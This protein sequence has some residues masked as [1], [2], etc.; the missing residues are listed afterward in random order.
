MQSEDWSTVGP[1][2]PARW[3][4][5][6]QRFSQA[7]PRDSAPSPCEEE[8]DDA[9][10]DKND[11]VFWHEVSQ[12]S[13]GSGQGSG[14]PG[15]S[16][17]AITPNSSYSSNGAA[18][19]EE[20]SALHLSKLT[21]QHPPEASTRDRTLHDTL[22]TDSSLP[23]PVRHRDS[24][25]SGSSLIANRSSEPF[26]K[27]VRTMSVPYDH[28]KTQ[29]Y[30]D[31]RKRS[32][33]ISAASLPFSRD[34]DL[35][36]DSALTQIR[37]QT[38]SKKDPTQARRH[39]RNRS[40]L[41]LGLRKLIGRRD[42][43]EESS[44][45]MI[46][47]APMQSHLS[48]L[49]ASAPENS[50]SR[51]SRMLSSRASH[52]QHA[53]LHGQTVGHMSDYGHKDVPQSSAMLKSSSADRAE[54]LDTFSTAESPLRGA[55]NPRA[56]S[57]NKS[58]DGLSRP[59]FPFPSRLGTGTN[60]PL[61]MQ[62]SPRRNVIEHVSFD[63]ARKS[64]H[65]SSPAKRDQSGT[66]YTKEE[67]RPITFQPVAK[68]GVEVE[69]SVHSHTPEPM[70]FGLQTQFHRPFSMN[71]THWQDPLNPSGDHSHCAGEEQQTLASQK[72]NGGGSR[73]QVSFTEES[74]PMK[75]RE[76]LLVSEPNLSNLIGSAKFGSSFSSSSALSA[77]TSNASN[78]GPPLFARQQ[79]SPS[80]ITTN[81]SRPSGRQCSVA[82]AP[83]NHRKRPSFGLAIAPNAHMAFD[84]IPSPTIRSRRDDA[85]LEAQDGAKTRSLDLSPRSLLSHRSGLPPA[86]LS[87]DNISSK[88][89]QCSTPERQRSTA[90][91]LDEGDSP[92]Q[93]QRHWALQERQYTIFSPAED[94]QAVKL[95][96]ATKDI[97]FGSAAGMVSKVFEHPFD[98]VKVRLQTQS[99][100]R[101]PQ[102]A[103]AFDCFKQTYL[104]EGVRG[105][106]RGLSMP[107]IGATLENACLF[108]TY[109]QIQRGLRWWKGQASS[110]SAL[111][112]DAE[113][114]LS[115]AQ[116][117][118]AG[119]G[120]GSVTSFVLTPIELIKCKMQV[121]MITR[122][123]QP[124]GNTASATSFASV[125][126]QQ[127]RSMSAL[128]DA[129]KLDGPLALVRRT[130]AADGL[131]GLWLGQTGTLLRETGG[132]TAWFLAFESC[133][134]Y[135][136]AKKKAASGRSDVTKKELTSL[137]LIG[138]G[139][140]SG[141]SYNVVLFPADSVKSTMQTEQEM[142]RSAT[143]AGTKFKGTG[144]FATFKKIYASR[145][146]RGLYAG[147]GVTCLR[148]APS[149][150]IIFLMYN[151][152]EAFADHHGL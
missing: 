131:R 127:V 107:V 18:I 15:P 65:S 43:G 147:C 55:R 4:T 81:F 29:T 44:E 70:R 150:A 73:A 98:L 119:A 46:I 24:Q 77:S 115:I 48:D 99:G 64:T 59:F 71:Y 5:L 136:I 9:M 1:S 94:G 50:L 121:Q 8:I 78:L 74:A 35:L 60:A 79:S 61:S 108:F 34:R 85:L 89:W 13:A 141:I 26:N 45:E 41:L 152:L 84:S 58:T 101:P 56:H 120:A 30:T 36:S 39:A 95:S 122:A 3:S 33:T 148:S 25:G 113:A 117:A 133:S 12:S 132:S 128:A 54:A 142:M 14:Q 114:P 96:Q 135:L 72:A 111:Q 51:R 32:S 40:S 109:N 92:P 47:S 49:T 31:A 116:L 102:Y 129:R 20:I 139:A 67:A 57:R 104:N 90:V 118:I 91:P 21:L 93:L 149:S 69:V 2:R 143:S 80:Q 28:H 37:P 7:A 11:S 66:H 82:S 140:I 146:L 97:T 68:A 126:S 137:E 22:N 130:I 145:G 87:S 112:A 110:N 106:Y 88:T 105:L 100:D 151:K 6:K 124:S 38:P 76:E 75:P 86:T 144:F 16:S 19:Q 52:E 134:R 62:A 103:G 138:A 123:H 63:E 10:W 125:G 83:I 23:L 27:H 53:R 42:S 17:L